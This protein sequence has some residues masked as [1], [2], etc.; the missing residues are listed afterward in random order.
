TGLTASTFLTG[1]TTGNN[2]ASVQ[3]TV[4][5]TPTLSIGSAATVNEGAT[6][7][8]NLSGTDPSPN[9]IDHWTITWGDCT[10]AQTVTGNPSSVTHLYA[11]GTH[12]YTISATATDQH[13][14]Y[15]AGNTVSVTVNNVAPTLSNVGI[16]SPVNQASP[17][18]LTGSIADPGTQDPVTLVVNWGDGSAPQTFHYVA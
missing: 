17:A 1:L 8:L 9:I 10:P 3:A 5:A 4:Y 18:T 12:Q 2:L 15:A 7:T 11:D 13:G 6:Y 14:T 16:T